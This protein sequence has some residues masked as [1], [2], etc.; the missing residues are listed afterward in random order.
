M[1]LNANKTQS[2]IVSRSR[3]VYPN[4]H[5]LFINNVVLTTCGSFKIWSVLFDSKFTFEQH[6]RCI[7]SSVA[8]KIGL[9]RKSYKIFGD[10]SV[11]RKCFNS[12]ILPCLEYCSPAWSSVAASHLKLL[13]RNVRA[14]KFLI[15]DLEVGLQHR[16]SVSS[17]CMLHKIFHNPRHP[18]NSELPNP[19]QSII[20]IC[21]CCYLSIFYSILIFFPFILFIF[22]ILGLPSLLVPSGLWHFAPSVGVCSLLIIIIIIPPVAE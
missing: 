11:L 7:S 16:R 20:V 5:D 4:H 19:F 14:C 22:S 17:L 2:M 12:F 10:P 9:L 6:V 21:F 3:T 13:D 8:Q 18:L 1:K 15:P